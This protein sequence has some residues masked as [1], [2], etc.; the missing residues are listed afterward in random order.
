MVSSDAVQSVIP[1]I[2]AFLVGV[3]VIHRAYF[4]PLQCWNCGAE[5]ARPHVPRIVQGAFCEECCP[6]CTIAAQGIEIPA[7][8]PKSTLTTI[9]S[10]FLRQCPKQPR[11]APKPTPDVQL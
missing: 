9:P 10:W 8:R 6:V 3:P 7:E 1:V 2:I 11:S 4:K 5:T